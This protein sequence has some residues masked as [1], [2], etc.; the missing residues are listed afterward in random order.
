[1]YGSPS[2]PIT[3][4][5]IAEEIEQ[6]RREQARRVADSGTEFPTRSDPR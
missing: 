4:E 2:R 1:V 6:M 5:A 3:Q